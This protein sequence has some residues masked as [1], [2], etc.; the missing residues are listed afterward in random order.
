M[1]SHP[2]ERW[3]PS[4]FASVVNN[5]HHARHCQLILTTT[6]MP[7]QQGWDTPLRLRHRPAFLS[8]PAPPLHPPTPAPLRN[9]RALGA[10]DLNAL[11][12]A[13]AGP[14]TPGRG[15]TPSSSSPQTT[16]STIRYL[17][18]AFQETPPKLKELEEGWRIKRRAASQPGPVE[19]VVVVERR[20]EPSE[21]RIER[22]ERRYRERDRAERRDE[23]IA[24]R[25]V[26]GNSAKVD[27]SKPQRG[28]GNVDRLKPP[29]DPVRS[30]GTD[31]DRHKPAGKAKQRA[32]PTPDPEHSVGQT[33]GLLTPPASPHPG[34]TKLRQAKPAR[35]SNLK[36]TPKLPVRF[37][38]PPLATSTSE[39]E[40]RSPP[41]RTAPV[42]SLR[43][44]RSETPISAPP[45][46]T[47]PSSPTPTVVRQPLPPPV[48]KALA[49]DDK[50]PQ[51]SSSAARHSPTNDYDSPRARAHQPPPITRAHPSKSR[52]DTSDPVPIQ[53]HPLPLTSHPE[54]LGRRS[55]SSDTIEV[56]SPAS[57]S[58]LTLNLRRQ[59]ART[60]R[61]GDVVTIEG[62]AP[63]VLRLSESGE[64]TSTQ[65]DLWGLFSRLV[66]EHKRR[67]ARVCSI[68]Y[69]ISPSV[70]LTKDQ[71]LYAAR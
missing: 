36:G 49:P 23:R 70:S 59:V 31:W 9:S 24:E 54:A 58:A 62:R 40:E 22:C 56:H 12:S 5:T 4:T 6:T 3:R 34:D 46:S 50:S 16:T 28:L 8:T 25:R 57:A 30:L 41:P 32:E 71:S 18:L 60:N 69:A 21:R 2:E 10:L 37:V 39:A 29:R 64:W 42:H 67:T 55:S 7:G 61:A 14:S 52:P 11:P 33:T 51:R 19:R 26:S 38:S 35:T 44:A 43:M 65:R 63:Q 17:R 1:M 13:I 66:A 53:V 27:C 47:R 68:P 15:D 48:F 20:S 45:D